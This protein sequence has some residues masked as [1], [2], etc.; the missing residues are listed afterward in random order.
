MAFAAP[1]ASILSESLTALLRRLGLRLKP[2]LDS[3]E[4]RDVTASWPGQTSAE[5]R[6]LLLGTSG[7]HANDADVDFTGRANP[8]SFTELVP[9]G[10]ALAKT[11]NGDFWVADIYQD[12]SWHQVFFLSHDPPVLVVRF[13]SLRNFIEELA[14]TANAAKRADALVSQIFKKRECGRPAGEL[15][16]SLDVELETFAGSFP[17][18]YEVFDLRKAPVPAGFVW[19]KRGAGRDR[20]RAGSSLLFAVE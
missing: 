10:I 19:G 12:G 20:R 15:T 7:F 17:A 2:G 18:N 11:R 1:R 8:L 14:N 3:E 4:I 6:E 5:I 9:H 16:S 13:G